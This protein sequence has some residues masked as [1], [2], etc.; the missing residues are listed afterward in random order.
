MTETEIVAVSGHRRWDSRGRPTVEATV[1]TRGGIG[2]AMAPAG[3]STGTGEAVDLRDGGEL[4]GGLD[5]TRAIANVNDRIAPALVGADADD[6]A[7]VDQILERLDGT[8]QFAELGGNATVAVSLATAWAAA[9][10]AHLPLWQALD[11]D[12]TLV[13]VPEI[14]IFGG[15]AH[16][17]R[18][19]DIQ[20]LMVVPVGASSFAEALTWVAEIHRA[21]G[22]WLDERGRRSGVADEGGW[23]PAFDTNQDALDALVAAIEGAGLTPGDQVGI[24][25]DIAASQFGRGGRYHLAREDRTLD[26]TELCELLAGWV[27]RYPIVSIEDP[28]AEDDPAGM[29]AF[30]AAVGDRIQVVGDDFLVTDAVHVEQAAVDRT[31]NTVLIKP[32]QAGTLT[33]AR[34]ALDTAQRLGLAT[35]VSARSGETEDVSVA[36]LA[37]GWSAGE[38]KVGSITR[39]ER[40]AKW[41]ELLR[42]EEALGA[43]ATFRP[44][45]GR[46][47]GG[48]R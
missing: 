18:R 29:A 36:H 34:A 17:H 5:V 2:R 11:P 16:A 27:D 45:L 1:Q 9:D 33:R 32:N 47:V 22:D 26:S 44:G 39:G 37:V 41:N 7:A 14:Q 43:A 6:Q 10:T 24:A 23:W 31:A 48:A 46:P 15:G 12:A 19:I 40:T 35:I 42:I 38:V 3:A 30:T 13:P 28:V 8:G 25:L 4:L 20:D 21:A